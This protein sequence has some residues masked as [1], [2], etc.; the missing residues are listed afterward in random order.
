MEHSAVVAAVAKSPKAALAAGFVASLT[1][2]CMVAVFP[3]S[4]EGVPPMYG[5]FEAQR[6]WL[7][8]TT[9]LP[10]RDWYEN[11]TDNDL[12]YWGLDYPPLTGFHSQLLGLAGHR[13]VPDCVALKTSRGHESPSC[14]AFMRATVILSDILVYMPGAWLAVHGLMKANS[15]MSKMGIQEAKALEVLATLG[16]WLLPPLVLIDHGHFQYNGVCFGLCLAA[17]GYVAMGRTLIASVFFTCALLFKQIALYYAFG[18]FVGILA[19]CLRPPCTFLTSITRIAVTGLTVLTTAA[20]IFL[21]W[22]AS[23]QPIPAVLQVLHRMFPFARGLYED[24]VANVWCTI[25]IVIKLQKLLP[26]SRIPIFCAVV[27]LVVLMPACFFCVLQYRRSCQA[28]RTG[29]DSGVASFIAALVASSMSFFLFAFQVHEKSILF[30]CVAVVL[31]PIAMPAERRPTW[32]AAAV[33]HFLLVCLFSM[34]PL[35]VKDKLHL[36]YV[37]F[38]VVLAVGC[39]LSPGCVPWY[40]RLAFRASFAMM[41]AFH[42]I[43]ALVP[44]PSRYPDLWTMLITGSSCAYFVLCLLALTVA[45]MLGVFSAPT[46]LDEDTKKLK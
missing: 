33:S 11:T 32:A 43:H 1:L 44:P 19:H 16:L 21:P 2:R 27:T 40:L 12:L 39:E 15:C 41:A 46:S 34:Y 8:I 5:D 10:R 18:F 17:V 14:R 9:A 28:S 42:G 37:A 26:A 38:C 7:E 3:H 20:L 31:L 4:G 36:P 22:L 24:K 45:Q 29:Q 25:S 30:P 23:T 6:H 35:I 13:L